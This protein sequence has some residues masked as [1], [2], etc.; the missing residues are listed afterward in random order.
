MTPNVFDGLLFGAELL[1]IPLCIA[2]YV[3]LAGP[4]MR[5]LIAFQLAGAVVAVQLVLLSVA[6][7]TDAFGDLG[8]TLALLS[9]GGAFAYA[10]FLERWL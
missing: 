10:H 1:F 8:L 4:T 9:T 5:R 7:G 2:L 3:V 6:F